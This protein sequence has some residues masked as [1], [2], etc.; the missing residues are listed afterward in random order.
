MHIFPSAAILSVLAASVPVT[1]A[2]T[3]TPE[4]LLA[5]AR[6]AAGGNA[7][8]RAVGVLAK[9]NEDSAGMKGHWRAADDVKSGRLRRSSDFGIVST[10]EVWDRTDHWRQDI[11]GGVHKLDSDFARKIAATAAWMARR[12]YLKPGYGHADL[13]PVETR[14]DGDRDYQIVTATP[15][16]GNA[17]ELW[18]DS[19]THLLARTRQDF[20]FT[21]DTIFYEDYRK[22]DQL[23]LPFTIKTDD[24]ESG[25]DTVHVSEYRLVDKLDVGAFA[26]PVAPDD[27][28]IAGGKVTVPFGFNGEI[29]VSAM[30]NGKGPYRFILDTG[31][32]DILTPEA[33]TAIGLE[34]EGAGASGGAG[35]GTLPEQFARVDTLQIGGV[36]MRNQPFTVIPLQ[37]NTVEDGPR[38]P[39]A[40]LLGLELFERMAIHLDYAAQTL[41][42]QPLAGYRHTGSGTA[43]PIRFY[44]D[45]PILDAKL[46]GH[47]GPFAVDTGN[48]GTLVVQRLWA[49]RVGV[50][51]QMKRGLAMVSFGAG[52]ESLDWTSRIAHF[53]LAGSDLAGVI[54]RYATDAGGAF[55]SRIEAGNIGNQIL[56]HFTLDFDYGREQIWFERQPAFTPLPFNRSGM[57]LSK[58]SPD[59]FTVA[60]VVAGGPAAAAGLARGDQIVSV[61]GIAAPQFTRWDLLNSFARPEGTK[62]DLTYLR[63]GKRTDV[64]LVL[65]TLLP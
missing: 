47:S 21:T 61:D 46:D 64:A 8:A 7:W 45:I 12:D 41:T 1:G 58:T 24:G 37:Y 49:D 39:L 10:D 36:T 51:E 2:Q 40:G 50:G 30:L 25:I 59:A 16:N 55:A 4:S 26:P 20:S 53:E 29:L 22:V 48:S 11:S 42:F 6:Q 54:G 32:H 5:Q 31:G 15:P 57:S 52:G 18:F 19:K 27:T 63:G 43:V 62:I 65:K 33:A 9:G 3:A 34:P 28:N 38:P 60:N 17:L 13:G 56:P 35:P 44:D 14:H 23:M